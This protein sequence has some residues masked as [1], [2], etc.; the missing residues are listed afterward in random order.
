MVWAGRELC[1]E[2]ISFSF[3][4]D[5]QENADRI[6]KSVKVEYE[7]LGPPLVTTED[8]VRANAY[9]D[10]M[11]PQVVKVG[12]VKSKSAVTSYNMHSARLLLPCMSLCL[13]VSCYSY[14]II[15]LRCSPLL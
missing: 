13:I 7:S 15:I 8:A 9:A 4:T 14:A 6:A 5:T 1:F 11:P 3:C 10:N 12:D 2:S